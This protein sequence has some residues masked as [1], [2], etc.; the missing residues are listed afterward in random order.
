MLSGSP[1]RSA[2]QHHVQNEEIE[3]L[4]IRPEET[5]FTG[6]SHDN[7]VVLRSEGGGDNLGQLALVFDDQ[8]PH[9][10]RCYRGMRDPILTFV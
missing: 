8:D 3:H 2:G 7:V 5:L 10:K 6:G 9:Y 4:R 1:D